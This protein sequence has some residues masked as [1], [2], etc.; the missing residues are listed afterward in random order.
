MIGRGLDQVMP[1]SVDPRLHEP[2]VQSARTYVELAERV[3]GPI[4]RA[5]PPAYV[6]GDAL[7]ELE[8]R[9]PDARVVNL[10]TALTAEGEPSREK[11]IHY[12]SH[13]RNVASLEAGGV[14][15]AVLANNHM[16]D[17]GVAGLHKTLA[18][19]NA[20]GIAS[21]GAGADAAAAQA[22]AVVEAPGGRIIV[23]G[24]AS[25]SSGVPASWR[26]AEDR[27]GV[28][29]VDGWPL[30]VARELADRI[31]PVRRDGDSVV[32]SVHWGSNWG[33]E[34]PAAQR[35][36]AHELIEVAGADLV[37]GHSSHH[38]RPIEIYR[39]RLILHGCG[40]F[41]TDYEG[42]TGH[43]AF[44]GDLSLAYFPV[45]ETSGRLERLT[46]VPFQVR[47]FQ[48]VRGTGADVAWLRETLDRYS[49]PFGV[50]VSREA[51]DTLEVARTG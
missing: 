29:L 16:L 20:A 7:A 33:Y 42:I 39:D 17:W 32:A 11:E 28:R 35:A 49:R 18:T 8:R 30:A 22:P 27:P 13:P 41:I 51:D 38:P 10:E 2:Y 36:L 47:R 37:H 50:E 48:L 43:E 9:A 14:D 12:R 15:V 19:L 44:R 46:I 1:W 25:T 21:V 34:V 6:W 5:V 40:D 3:N 4:P 45:L 23:V 26:A 24:L 31:A